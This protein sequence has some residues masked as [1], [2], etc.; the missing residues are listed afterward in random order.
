[1]RDSLFTCILSWIVQKRAVMGAE[2]ASFKNAQLLSQI[3]LGIYL[4]VFLFLFK[5]VTGNK[6]SPGKTSNSAPYFTWK[7]LNI[8]CM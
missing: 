2:L 7:I 8:F 4:V 1:M 6:F 5:V 3:L